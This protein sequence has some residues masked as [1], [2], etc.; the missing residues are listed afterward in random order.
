M[1]NLEQN[2]L[3]KLNP[4]ASMT[5]A[6]QL[7]NRFAERINSRLLVPGSRL[8]SVRQCAQQQQ[9]S[10]S[11]VVAAYDQLLAFGLVEARKNRGFFVR[12]SIRESAQN[13]PSNIRITSIEISMQPA[14]LLPK[15]LLLI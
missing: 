11:T 9:V 14:Y 5:L 8:P 4:S 6:E 3:E 1:T 15:Q 13:T 10:P 2:M 12:E 7:S